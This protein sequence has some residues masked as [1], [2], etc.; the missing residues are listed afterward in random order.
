MSNYNSTTNGRNKKHVDRLWE[1]VR[2]CIDASYLTG[3]RRPNGS[4][5]TVP[6]DDP[7]AL[8]RDWV[9]NQSMTDK[10]NALEDREAVH[11]RQHR[12]GA[13]SGWRHVLSAH[14]AARLILLHNI[15]DGSEL[16]AMPDATYMLSCRDTA[17]EAVVL[18]FLARDQIWKTDGLREALGLLDYAQAVRS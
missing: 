7:R 8:L 6:H 16:P 15:G 17:A 9:R 18:G 5:V 14:H 11:E 10:M 4:R 12:R 1:Q 13:P 3:E 2:D